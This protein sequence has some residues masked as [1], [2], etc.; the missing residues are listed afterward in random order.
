MRW[1]WYGLFGYKYYHHFPFHVDNIHTSVTNTLNT[2]TRKAQL[3]PF[4]HIKTYLRTCDQ[5]DFYYH[6]FIITNCFAL[7]TVY[8]SG[9][10]CY[11]QP[12]IILKDLLFSSAVSLQLSK[13]Y[14]VAVNLVC[15]Y[16]FNILAAS[17]ASNSK[18][19]TWAVSL[20]CLLHAFAKN[21]MQFLSK[22]QNKV[23]HR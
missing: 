12:P 18:Q 10:F 8:C 14:S 1:C 19:I 6:V 16:L 3:P 17:N 15:L 21:F 13:I 22:K 20:S 9:Y 23:S 5:N 4:L 7:G 2:C 11:R